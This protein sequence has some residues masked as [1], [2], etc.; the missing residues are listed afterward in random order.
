MTSSFCSSGGA[1]GA[2]AAPRGAPPGPRPRGSEHEVNIACLKSPSAG[3]ANGEHSDAGVQSGR[4]MG[5]E[6][7]QCLVRLFELRI[8]FLI[9]SPP[10]CFFSPHSDE[11]NV[12]ARK[13]AAH[14]E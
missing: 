11:W 7:G 4:Q 5:R 6:R 8:A 12:E 1:P 13:V 10:L 2:F 9:T 14:S 3:L